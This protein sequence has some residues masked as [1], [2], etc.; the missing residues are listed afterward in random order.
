MKRA[1][2]KLRRLPSLWSGSISLPLNVTQTSGGLRVVGV[3]SEPN[4]VQH[5]CYWD[6]DGRPTRLAELSGFRMSAA[7]SITKKHVIVGSCRE[8]LA[9]D[10]RETACVWHPGEDDDPEALDALDGH[11]SACATAIND[12]GV[13]IGH[14]YHPL[15]PGSRT[16]VLW[17]EG[18]VAALRVPQ[19]HSG[20]PR[21]INNKNWIVG[22]VNEGDTSG[23]AVLWF[24]GKMRNFNLDPDLVSCACG[25]TDELVVVGWLIDGDDRTCL[26]VWQGD[27]EKP[28]L[29]LDIE[30]QIIARD[31]PLFHESPRID[32]SNGLT[33][34]ASTKRRQDGEADVVEEVLW[35]SVAER[36]PLPTAV[37]MEPLRVAEMRRGD[38]LTTVMGA[39]NGH[40]TGTALFYGDVEGYLLLPV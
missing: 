24:K 38:M 32:T 6:A 15:A 27:A 40:V 14:S 10:E 3:S 17:A 11:T 30:P 22:N 36:S 33:V 25:I 2:F 1:A 31:L 20:M 19:D 29:G 26:W 5:A 4:R 37:P 18:S 21:A 34:W 8:H 9:D 23:R 7:Y 16:P 13:I 28:D 39:S 35:G 12:S